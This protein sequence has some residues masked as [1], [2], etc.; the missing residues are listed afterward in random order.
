MSSQPKDDVDWHWNEMPASLL[1]HP[2]VKALYIAARARIAELEALYTAAPAHRDDLVPGKL[3]CAKCNFSLLRTVLNVSTG[4]ACA[5]DNKT[6]ACP[7][8]C[9]PLWPMT[10]EQ[11]AREGYKLLDNL[12]ERAKA[13]EDAIAAHEMNRDHGSEWEQS[14]SWMKVVKALNKAMPGWLNLSAVGENCAVKAIEIMA[15]A[16]EVQKVKEPVLSSLPVAMVI[17][18]G[19]GERSLVFTG[20]A[21]AL[22]AHGTL[23]YAAAPSPQDES[24]P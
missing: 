9:G 17:A 13:A 7:N 3:R 2:R 21:I 18:H 6:E 8:G 5:G 1:N 24:K 10:W 11:E 19:R 12:F 15:A 22:P 23:L 4:N 14:S 20:A 16:H